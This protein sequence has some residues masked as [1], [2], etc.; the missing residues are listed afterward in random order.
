VAEAAQEDSTGT[1]VNIAGT[2][3]TAKKT[4]A[5]EARKVTNPP[6]AD[7]AG[8][9]FKVQLMAVSKDIELTPS[10]FK[11]LNTLS[12]EPINSMY[13]ILYGNTSSYEQ[14]KV[15]Q[16]GARQKGYDQAYIVAYKDGQRIAVDKALTYLSN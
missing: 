15:L 16:A 4:P 13:R 11:G 2:P 12:K 8:V 6:V 7:N 1:P 5:A 14:A 9:T 3:E 10:N